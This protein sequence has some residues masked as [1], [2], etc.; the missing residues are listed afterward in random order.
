MQKNK[1]VYDNFKNN[2]YILCFMHK[3]YFYSKILIK[4]FFITKSRYSFYLS[5]LKN[6]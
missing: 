4:R 3:K 5:D 1:L 6:Y 2:I